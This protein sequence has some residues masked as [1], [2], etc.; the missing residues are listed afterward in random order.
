MG[1][2]TSDTQRTP[3]E[4]KKRNL[5]DRTSRRPKQSRFASGHVWST[6]NER[7][8]TS[9]PISRPSNLPRSI[10]DS[11]STTASQQSRRRKDRSSWAGSDKLRSPYG[12]IPV[13]GEAVAVVGLRKLPEYNGRVGIVKAVPLNNFV[14]ARTSL[15]RKPRYAV[16]LP[17]WSQVLNI[18]M[19]N[20]CVLDRVDVQVVVQDGRHG[21]E[22]HKDDCGWLV[23]SI[24]QVPR[25]PHLRR[26][27]ILIAVDGK[28][29]M[30][31]SARDQTKLV[32]SFLKDGSSVTVLRTPS[33]N[34]SRRE[35]ARSDIDRRKKS[36][37]SSE[38]RRKRTLSQ[39]SRL[40]LTKSFQQI[41]TKARRRSTVT[42]SPTSA[43]TNDVRVSVKSVQDILIRFLEVLRKARH[44]D[45]KSSQVHA[46]AEGRAFQIVTQCGLAAGGT[47]PSGRSG[48]HENSVKL[49]DFMA[50]FECLDGSKYTDAEIESAL[51][52]LLA[53]KVNAS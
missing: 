16:F 8:H 25:Q 18:K 51:S 28:S 38:F 43:S 9:E 23:T 42:E 14:R 36:T 52:F 31:K 26:R 39:K 45:S 7:E 46:W 15:R 1:I 13:K 19:E 33:R 50:L 11:R 27:D 30:C 20:L 48:K 4:D 53:S 44:P 49:N 21:L 40:L 17:G 29:L 35:R 47:S 6:G 37:A 3:I 22:F 32:N 41:D 5:R 34:R 12:A 24:S 2:C 10:L